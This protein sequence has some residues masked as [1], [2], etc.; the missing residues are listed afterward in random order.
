MGKAV[1][2]EGRDKYIDLILESGEMMMGKEQ[3][4]CSVWLPAIWKLW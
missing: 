4:L 2:R 1:E 3:N